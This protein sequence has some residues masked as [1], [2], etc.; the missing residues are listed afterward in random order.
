MIKFKDIN[1][2]PLFAVP[3]MTVDLKSITPEIRQHLVNHTGAIVRPTYQQAIANPPEVLNRN[4]RV[5]DDEICKPLKDEVTDR[6]HECLHDILGATRNLDF[7]ISDSW[8][9]KQEPNTNMGQHSHGNSQFSG[10]IYLQTTAQSGRI[11]FHKRKHFDNVFPETLTVPID[12]PNPVSINMWPFEPKQDSLIL[13]PSNLEHSV[14]MNLSD[15]TRVS[16]AFNV[17]GYG[18]YGYEGNTQ[19]VVNR[20]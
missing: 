7:E 4:L 8:V 1:L 11:F 5:F 13:F 9:S 12:L 3:I 10:V 20:S 14:E 19:I 17:T 2:T 18:V 16:L 6:V 15:Q